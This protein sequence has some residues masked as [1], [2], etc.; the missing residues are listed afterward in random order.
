MTLM[1]DA[2]LLLLAVP[3]PALLGSNHL[4][5]LLWSTEGSHLDG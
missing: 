3:I 5:R 1:R 4:D 2:V